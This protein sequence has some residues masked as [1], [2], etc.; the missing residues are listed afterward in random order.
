VTALVGHRTGERLLGAAVLIAAP[1]ACV[2]ASP[3]GLALPGY[4]RRVL[5]NRTLA[6]SVTEWGPSTIQGQP[7]FFAALLGGAALAFFGRRR[8]TPFALVA[9]VISGAFGVLAI[10]NIVWF[11]FVAAAVLPTALDAVWAPVETRRRPGFNL[12]L[13]LAGAG[14]LLGFAGAMLSHANSWYETSFPPRAAAVVRSATQAHPG[15]RV[16]ANDE[17]ADWLLFEDPGLAGRVAYDI[18]FELLTNAELRRIVNFQHERGP[19]WRRAIDGYRVLVLDPK[20][21]RDALTWLERRGARVLY[22]DP[23]V[24]VMEKRSQ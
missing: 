15:A 5:D 13:G 7:V 3:Y 1:W 6:H 20:S 4:Y 12:I 22:R 23:Q 24:V 2:L 16:F 8:L 19:D 11:A 21:N 18:R 9:L 17:F 14:M 10:R